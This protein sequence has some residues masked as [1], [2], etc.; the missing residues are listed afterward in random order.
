MR[1]K[2]LQVVASGRV[3]P[4]PGASHQFHAEAE[5][6]RWKSELCLIFIHGILCA[7][8]AMK[9]DPTGPG[10]PSGSCSCLSCHQADAL[11]STCHYLSPET[12]WGAGWAGLALTTLWKSNGHNGRSIA[13]AHSE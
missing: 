11:A 1:D 2:G 7:P 4:Q 12:G 10:W 9:V 6:C 13:V 3:W 8:D 5:K